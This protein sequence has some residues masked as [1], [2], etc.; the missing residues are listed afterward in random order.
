[1][2]PT[3]PRTP[4]ARLSDL[5]G[6]DG[7]VHPAEL[8]RYDIGPFT[9]LAAVRP[10]D[11]QE[12]TAVLRW[13]AQTS[14]AVYPSGGRTQIDLGNPPAKPGIA[15]DLTRLDRLVDFQP[16]DLTISA[17]AGMTIA[18]LHDILAQD[19]KYVPI[20]A[21]LPSRATIGGTLAAG[22]SGPLRAAYGLPRD[23]LIGIT[24]ADANG[25]LT[26]AGGKVVKNVTG[27]DLN[28]IYTGSL[29]SL[30]VTVETTFKLA[31]A[32]QELAAVVA[33]FPNAPTAIHAAQTLQN[34]H[35]APL[36][37]H[38]LNHC[39]AAAIPTLPP[40]DAP[41]FTA[42]ALIGGR[43][44][45]VRR[46]LH[47]T[48]ALWQPDALSVALLQN[49]PASDLIAAL[50]DLPAHPTATLVVRVNAPPSEITNFFNFTEP[51]LP[52]PALAADVAF[53]G[54]RLLWWDD[55]TA[56][57]PRI[58]A[59]ALQNIQQ[60]AIA[61]GGSAVIERCPHPVKP[62]LDVWGPPPSGIAVM[63]RLKAQFDPA[64]ILNPGRFV[65]GL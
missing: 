41:E 38:L 21:P 12:L 29:G 11:R 6:P 47:D 61:A 33:R 60:S 9:P 32:S 39:A 19:G 44:S 40:I 52:P 58:V 51:H 54:A 15:L 7:T 31:P 27:Y 5:I 48:A 46:R 65:G 20:S 63:R 8:T 24:V 17:E 42:I 57:D 37:L 55:F 53:G 23:W 36:G 49:D 50:T 13:A 45:S 2:S 18:R 14:T 1:M 4:S 10:A 25:V 64:G 16:A 59:A 30:A 28:R 22:A 34:Q 3:V 62:C 43:A 35:Y 26:N 56:A